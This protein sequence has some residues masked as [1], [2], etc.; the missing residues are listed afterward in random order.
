TLRAYSKAALSLAEKHPEIKLI[1]STDPLS[2]AGAAAAID[3][4]GLCG[5]IKI[6]GIGRPAD[7]VGYVRNDCAPAIAYP[8]YVDHGYLMYYTA[9]ALAT[10]AVAAK[11]G[12]RFTAGRLGE[13]TIVQDADRLLRVGLGPLTIYDK[14]NIEAAVK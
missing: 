1:L 5:K 8:D 11:D 9:Y 2:A 6:A 12:E 10:G 14:S 4:A 13:R 7:M 3:G